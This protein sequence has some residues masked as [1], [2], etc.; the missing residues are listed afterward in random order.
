M[1]KASIIA[2]AAM[3]A[4]A[5]CDRRE[6]EPVA[7]P[8]NEPPIEAPSDLPGDTP[9][10]DPAAS[11]PSDPADAAPA[12]A[13]VAETPMIE[14]KAD[15]IDW[16]ATTLHAKIVT[17]KGD[18]MVDLYPDKAPK[19]V[20]NFVQYAADGHYDQLIFHRV[21]PGFV[22]QAGGYT[23]YFNERP[24]RDPI[25]YEGDNGLGNYR[26]TLAMARTS[27]PASAT[28]QFYVNLRD[29][30]E[31]LDH[32]VNDLGPRYGY[33]VFGRVVGGMDVADAIG[34][35]ATGPAGPFPAEVPVETV[36]ISRIDIIEE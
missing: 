17:S 23:K 28:S 29:N 16:P 34:A 31:L 4:L 20:A 22:V 7:P 6:A 12:D 1:R 32:Y 8:Q 36:V 13:P 33:T 3:L 21:V 26:T 24:T 25:P 2:A 30:N 15:E 11:A 14:T 35:I 10:N 9:I 19:T 18:M 27:N 5:A